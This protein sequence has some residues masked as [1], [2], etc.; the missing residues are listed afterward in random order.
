MVAVIMLR[1]G[2]KLSVETVLKYAI[3]TQ[4]QIM[5]FPICFRL[6]FGIMLWE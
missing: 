5:R 2:S 3:P 1:G 4:D 6:M